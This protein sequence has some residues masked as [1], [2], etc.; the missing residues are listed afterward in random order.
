MNKKFFINLLSKTLVTVV[1][2]LISLILIKANK[3]FKTN[4]YK[5]V[6]GTNFSFSKINNIYNKYVGK[7]D[8]V[9]Q[10]ATSEPVFNEKLEYKKIEKYKEGVKLSVNN[11][12]LVP[13]QESGIVVFI[14]EKEG[15]GNT[16][17]IQRLDGIDE[18]YGN[19]SNTDLKLYDYVK[20]GEL[21]GEVDK[22]LYLVYRKNGKT[23]NYEEYIKEN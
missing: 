16:V 18:W 2:M 19:I 14:G 22:E 17:I 23:L 10:V 7:P 4:F 9:D 12:Y 1:L 8:I 5:Q 20:K 6:Y 11:N 21:L 13:I 15:Y 3:S